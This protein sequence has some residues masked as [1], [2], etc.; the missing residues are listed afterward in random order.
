MAER[1]LI[2]E[3]RD[4]KRTGPSVPTKNEKPE[5]KKEYEAP[6][7]EEET[8]KEAEKIS[9]TSPFGN[10]VFEMIKKQEEERKKETTRPKMV[11]VVDTPTEVA[12]KDNSLWAKTKRAMFG[13]GGF[14][15]CAEKMWLEG[16]I[17]GF[18]AV[19]FDGLFGGLEMFFFG[20]SS[21]RRYGG[22]S[23]REA[24][25]SSMYRRERVRDRDRRRD[26]DDF[27]DDEDREPWERVKP[28]TYSNCKRVL[29]E[30]ERRADDYDWATAEDL[31][32]AMDYKGRIEFTEILKVW[33][34][35]DL[36]KAIIRE[37]RGGY[38]LDMPRYRQ[39]PDYDRDGRP[40]R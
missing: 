20:E 10:D 14:G 16:F 4:P 19:M 39:N 38:I 15:E 3:G 21:G 35:D 18:K 26:D 29:K 34:P 22:R 13:D 1:K 6:V 7:I 40:R 8:T 9:A 31:L 27:Y 37:V 5:E 12:K 23:I 36:R 25:Y 17:P 24:G 2:I 30:M 28:M 33:Y 11:S 32:I